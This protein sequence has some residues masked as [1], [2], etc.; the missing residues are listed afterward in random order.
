MHVS[1]KVKTLFPTDGSI[2]RTEQINFVQGKYHHQTK[3][4]IDIH[5]TLTLN[6]LI[7]GQ[8]SV[9]TSVV[10]DGNVFMVHVIEPSNEEE[11]KEA[12]KA[13][14]SSAAAQKEAENDEEIEKSETEVPEKTVVESK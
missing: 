1:G 9:K 13:E 6:M 12:L 8:N 2:I 10:K 4:D 5:N 11:Q 3:F 14:Q 7:P